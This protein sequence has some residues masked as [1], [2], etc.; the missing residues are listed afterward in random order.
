MR[1]STDRRERLSEQIVDVEIESDEAVRELI[2]LTG[3]EVE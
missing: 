3:H 2:Q 1:Q